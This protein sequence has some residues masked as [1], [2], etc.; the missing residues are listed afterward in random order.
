MPRSTRAKPATAKKPAKQPAKKT[1][2]ASKK[3]IPAKPETTKRKTKKALLIELLSRPEG[4]TINDMVETT[5]WLP[6]T[7][8]AA[9][10]RLRQAG[11]QIVRQ[12][13]EKKGSVYRIRDDAPGNDE[14][15]RS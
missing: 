6:H 15:S 10:T 5:G 2:R 12:D 9:L 3:P 13:A 4:A 11:H 1:A 8:R 14:E 7:V